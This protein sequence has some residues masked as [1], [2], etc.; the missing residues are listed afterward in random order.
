VVNALLCDNSVAESIALDSR[1]AMVSFTGSERVGWHLRSL[2]PEKP[3][4]L[5]LG[6]DASAL[7][8]PDADLDWAVARIATSA[9]G[10]AGQVCISAQ[11]MRV[12]RPV[13]DEVRERMIAATEAT[14]TGDPLREETVCGPLISAEAAERVMEW[15]AEAESNGATVLAGGNRVG[16]VV[17]PTL[18]EGVGRECRLATDEVFG[19]VLT[20]SR[21][22][23]EDHG[24]SMVNQS[25]F[26]IHASVFTRDS[27]RI[28]RAYRSL[29]VSGVIAN[30][31]PTL[32]FD[33]MPYGGL[34][35]SG[36]GRE[37]VCY[38]YDEYTNPKVLLERR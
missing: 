5:E 10:Y 30:D 24:Y 9:Y 22:E 19:P 7:V 29:Q 25:R 1:I 14:P 27:A 17:E 31:F 16:N 20:L 6:G 33:A 26:G 36:L 4:V 38:A 32:R 23:D 28:E 15:I 34:K 12:E 13:Y 37:G 18:I 35:R 11:H 3:I 8:F 21:F 2:L